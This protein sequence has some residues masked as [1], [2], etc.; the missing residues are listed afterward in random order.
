MDR[1]TLSAFAGVV[2]LDGLNG[3]GVAVVNEEIAPLWGTAS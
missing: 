2:L 3:V 1:T